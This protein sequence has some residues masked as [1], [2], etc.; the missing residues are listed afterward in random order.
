MPFLVACRRAQ[1]RLADARAGLLRTRNAVPGN[2]ATIGI[3]WSFRTEKRISCP[4]AVKRESARCGLRAVF[5]H[6]V[7]LSFRSRPSSLPN[8]TPNFSFGCIRGGNVRPSAALSLY[9]NCHSEVVCLL[10]NC[11]FLDAGRRLAGARRPPREC[12]GGG[13]LSVKAIL[14]APPRALP[15][16]SAVLRE[17]LVGTQGARSMTL[18]PGGGSKLNSEAPGL[19]SKARLLN[20]SRVVL[21]SRST[22]SVQV[23][24]PEGRTTPR[25]SRW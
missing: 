21:P 8:G 1:G 18:L 9:A 19:V 22:S 7:A 6:E 3:Q 23:M 20:S 13:A 12:G 4:S 11:R 25:V 16:L 14:R 24:S 15:Q 2:S 10:E 17:A 5:L